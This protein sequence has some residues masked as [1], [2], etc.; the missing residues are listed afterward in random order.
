MANDRERLAEI[1]QKTVHEELRVG[2]WAVY[3]TYKIIE[4]EGHKFVRAPLT[5]DQLRER[6]IFNPLSRHSADL[7]L[8]FAGWAGKYQ[9]DREA[10]AAES[11]KNQ[12]AALRWARTYGVLGV[13]PPYVTFLG[14][15]TVAVEDY[16]GRP[17]ADGS[18]GR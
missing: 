13:N 4:V 14:T 1:Y 5:S 7:F 16:L 11:K 18:A 8:R 9:M 15:S 3:R 6:Q 17:G 10:A 2:E 12:E